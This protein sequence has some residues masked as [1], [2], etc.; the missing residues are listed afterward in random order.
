MR[1]RL[2]AI[3]SFV[4]IPLSLLSQSDSVIALPN[5]RWFDGQAFQLKAAYSVNGRL[6]FKRPARVD[7]TIDLA[8]S[9]VVPPFADAHSHSFGLG[10][11][12]A[13]SKNARRYLAAGVFYVQ[14]QGNLPMTEDAK[15]ALKLNTPSG[16]DAA[17]SNATLTAHGSALH[18]FFTSM[19]LPQGIFPGHTLETLNNVRYFEIDTAEEMKAKWPLIL[20][21]KSDFIKTYLWLTD[22]APFIGPPPLM[23]KHALQPEVFRDIVRQAHAS[24]LRVSAHVVSAGDFKVAVEGGADQIAHLPSIGVITPEVAK[25]AARRG[26]SVVT[27]M[28]QAAA[29][30]DSIRLPMREA[31]VAMRAGALRNLKTLTANGVTIVI[32]A[33]TPADTTAVEAAYLQSLGLFDNAAMLRMWAAVTPQVIFPSRKIG[34]LKEGYEASFLALDADPLANWTATGQIRIRFKQ[35]LLMDPM[36]Q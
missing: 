4:L 23:G 16:I 9:W 2:T 24:G 19:I 17:L 13:D 20:A 6:T 14:S 32:G 18:A 29:P 30:V 35:G 3:L 7:R 8:G 11:P 31:A 33:D 10:I 21:Q 25:Q 15:V 12:G 36:P 34:A 5:G 27:T 22:D 1:M 26:V 28:A